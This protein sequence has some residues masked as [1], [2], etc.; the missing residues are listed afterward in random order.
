M[1]S[2]RRAGWALACAVLLAV[3]SAPSAVA[4]DG[5][6]IFS[7]VQKDG[8]ATWATEKHVANLGQGRDLTGVAF[9]VPMEFQVRISCQVAAGDTASPAGCA[10]AAA[11]CAGVSGAVGVGFLYDILTRPAG[12]NTPWRYLGSTCFADQVP[13]ATPTVTV[14]QIVQAFHLTPWATA[15]LATQP[16]GNTTLVGL[17]VYARIIWSDSGY[18]PGEIDT[19]DPTTMLGLTVQI[20]PRVDHYTYVF[21]DGSTVGPTRSDGGV[22]PTGDITHAYPKPGRYPARVDTT[23][24]GDFSINGGPWSQIPDTVTVTGPTTIITVHAANP[25]LV[26]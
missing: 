21:G 6:D 14:A 23:F 3:A 8:Q 13:G 9:A 1:R 26:G 7:S 25:I 18:Q 19:L 24:T 22:W 12:S 16:E 20:R 10:R 15:T 17:P 5:N 11:S 4:G 2:A